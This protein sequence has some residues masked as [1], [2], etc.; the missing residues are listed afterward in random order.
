MPIPKVE[1]RPLWILFSSRW[2]GPEQ[3][4]IADM[5]DLSNSGLQ[6]ALLCIAG[7]PIHAAASRNGKIKIYTIESAPYSKF[8]LQL[9]SILKK[10]I[11]EQS[12]NI[13]HLSHERWLWWLNLAVPVKK[14]MAFISSRH[15]LPKR[16]FAGWFNRWLLKRL[17]YMIVLNNSIRER[18]IMRRM[19]PE[20]KIRIVNLGLDFSRFDPAKIH[21]RE[22]IRKTWSVDADTIVIGSVGR[23]APNVGH[24][25]FIKAAA[26]LMK[27]KSQWKMKFVI[28][29]EE[30][31]VPNDAYLNHLKQLAEIMHIEEAVHFGFVKEELPEIMA[32]FDIYVM[33]GIEAV[34]GLGA[35]EA[36]AMERPVVLSNLIGADEIVAQDKF[37]LLVRPEDAYDLQ[38]NILKILQSP[39]ERLRMGQQGRKYVIQNFG[40]KKRFEE[41]LEL[42]EKCLK[43]RRRF[44]KTKAAKAN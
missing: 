43:R 6:L 37:G 23:L 28:L 20:K 9:I 5:I 18:L 8:D 25:T 42:Y 4:A 30:P 31:L 16:K 11:T 15:T 40:K 7:S 34:P 41:T 32:A 14:E 26:S 17:D 33:P 2:S 22:Q 27:Y 44:R 38:L 1:I 21:Q 10:V 39:A 24:E 36:L 3:L 13:I 29:A 12:P 35:L 19:L